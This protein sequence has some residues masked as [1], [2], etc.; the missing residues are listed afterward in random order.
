MSLRGGAVA[1]IAFGFVTAALALAQ[2]AQ[3][4]FRVLHSFCASSGCTQSD[5]VIRGGLLRTADGTLYGTT[6]RGGGDNEGIL[7][8]DSERRS[9][10]I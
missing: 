5:D 9:L 8:A 7:L 10:A 6:F 2:P 4:K 3:A 1:L